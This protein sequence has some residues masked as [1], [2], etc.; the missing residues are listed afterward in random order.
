MTT[1]RDCS[2]SRQ[3]VRVLPLPLTRHLMRAVRARRRIQ[4]SR[5]RRRPNDVALQGRSRSSVEYEPHGFT[6]ASTGVRRR[7]VSTTST[8]TSCALGGDTNVCGA[9]LHAGQCRRRSSR[10]YEAFTAI[11]LS[12]VKPEILKAYDVRAYTEP[13]WTARPVRRPLFARVMADYEKP[14]L[15]FERARAGQAPRGTE[16]AG[17]RAGS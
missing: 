10:T 1:R 16:M 13:T 7:G 9:S 4:T 17:P 15:R 12:A 11:R 2:S 5:Q 6:S 8:C 3:I 14:S